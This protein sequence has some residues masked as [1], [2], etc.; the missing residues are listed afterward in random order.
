[1]AGSICTFLQSFVIHPYHS[2]TVIGVSSVGKLKCLEIVKRRILFTH[3][4]IWA[5]FM[6]LQDEIVLLQN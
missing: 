6:W 2:V 5:Y 4:F 3:Y 1:M